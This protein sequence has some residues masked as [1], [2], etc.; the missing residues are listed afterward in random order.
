MLIHSATQR[1]YCAASAP[2][3]L[4]GEHGPGHIMLPPRNWYTI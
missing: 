1:K 4:K 2:P 3:L